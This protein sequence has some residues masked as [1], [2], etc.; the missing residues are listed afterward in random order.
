MADT[1][2]IAEAWDAAG[3]Y[4]VG[5]FGSLRWAEWNGRY[6]DDVRRFWRGDPHMI[7]PLATRLAGS[8]DLYQASG[9]RPYHSINFITSHDGFTLNDLVS[10]NDKHN[11]ANGEDNRDGDNN[12]LQLQLRRR[13]PHDAAAAIETVRLRQIKNM[14]ATLLLSQGVPM[15]LVRRRVPPH[16]AGQQQRLLPGQRHFLVQLAAG[17]SETSSLFRFC[18]ALIAFRKAEPTVRRPTSS[19]ASRC[20]RA[21]C[22]T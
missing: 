4:Q 20:G 17:A 14:L 1:K 5:T 15:L 11:E 21:A 3:A 6:R 22:P 7:G 18:Q 19:P 13:R 8:S 16:P 9:R 10:Y 2:I 12:N